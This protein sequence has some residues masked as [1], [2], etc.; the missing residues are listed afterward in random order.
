MSIFR[1]I[2]A[3]LIIFFVITFVSCSVEAFTISPNRVGLTLPA[4]EDHAG[5]FTVG[6]PGDTPVKIKV[7]VQDWSSE[8][9]GRVVTKEEGSSLS[10]IKFDPLE[11]ELEPHQ[12]ATVNYD[13]TLPDDAKGEYI[14][15]VFF[16]NIPEPSEA[17]I[18]VISRI[19]NSLYVIIEGT[20]VVEAEIGD[21][22]IKSAQPLKVD[23]TVENS[24]NVHIRPKGKMI[25]RRKGLFLSQKDKKPIEISFNKGGFPV[26]PAREYVYT[27]KSKETLKPGKYSL[28]LDLEYGDGSYLKKIIEFK[29][30]KKGGAQVTGKP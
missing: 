13:I 12:S 20:E 4:G 5:I 30:D 16:S 19:G 24:G 2:L 22:S 17:A 23:V 10:W 11:V 9:Y 21:V 25:I 8:Q 6:N 7:S 15:M 18:S 1:H 28:E 14:A 29:T 3:G 26:L 27:V